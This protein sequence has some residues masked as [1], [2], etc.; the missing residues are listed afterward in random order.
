MAA[1]G[2]QES[3][4]GQMGPPPRPPRRIQIGIPE[5]MSPPPPISAHTASHSMSSLHMLSPS[6]PRIQL[7]EDPQ[8][9]IGAGVSRTQSLRNQAKHSRNASLGRSSSLRDATD[10]S[11]TIDG[12]VYELIR[13]TQEA[14]SD[15]PL[16]RRFRT[17]PLRHL[18]HLPLPLLPCLH[19]SLAAIRA[20]SGVINRST[21]ATVEGGSTSSAPE[22]CFRPIRG[23]KS[24]DKRIR[25]PEGRSH[26][27][28]ALSFHPCGQRRRAEMDGQ[29]LKPCPMASTTYR[30]TADS[31][32]ATIWAINNHSIHNKV[33][34]VH[35]METSYPPCP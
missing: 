22:P 3:S 11:E 13:S 32:M 21:M 27:L 10:V 26:L 15:R 18:I 14:I 6:T 28:Q 29:A 25:N 31:T 20:I 5:S 2:V 7:E 1:I 24:V 16:L 30:S 34:E 12:I 35:P 8:V 33:V 23:T 19:F 9:A 17:L 4:K